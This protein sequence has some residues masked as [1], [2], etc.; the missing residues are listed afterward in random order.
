MYDKNINAI[1]STKFLPSRLKS[2]ET[3]GFLK[4]SLPFKS[5]KPFKAVY[6]IAYESIL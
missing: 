3:P 5:L 2:E 4:S 6:I 1:N